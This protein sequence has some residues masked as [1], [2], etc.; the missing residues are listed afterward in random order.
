MKKTKTASTAEIQSLK[1]QLQALEEKYARAL[2][3]YQNLQKR[4]E[5]DQGRFIKLANATLLKS[6]LT[7][8]DNLEKAAV[9]LNDHGLN[10]VLSEFKNSFTTAGLEELNPEDQPFDPATM[11]CIG[12]K[13]GVHDH[14]LEVA[15]KG[16]RLNGITLRP[17]KV[18]VGKQK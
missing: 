17:A 15:Q 4:T 9:H 12:T 11:E 1:D 10:L 8:F 3:D 16:Y 13:P 2:A 14:V 7:A 6:Q 5:E 18:I